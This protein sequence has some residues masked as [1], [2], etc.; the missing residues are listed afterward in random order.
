ML[1]DMCAAGG[2]RCER[3]SAY[4]REKGPE[5][6]EVYQLHG[7]WGLHMASAKVRRRANSNPS[8][9]LLH[10]ASPEQ[11]LCPVGMIRWHPRLR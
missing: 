8:A 4:L 10:L 3:A 5:F 6:Q 1:H 7:G 2:V 9:C 11:L